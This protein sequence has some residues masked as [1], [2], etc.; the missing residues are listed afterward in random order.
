MSCIEG[1]GKMN[2]EEIKQKIQEVEE[3]LE[4]TKVNMVSIDYYDKLLQIHDGLWALLYFKTN[5]EK[6]F[7]T[8]PKEGDG[9]KERVK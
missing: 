2:E 5:L 3:Q 6:D 1:Q 7:L 4:I 9:K 8:P